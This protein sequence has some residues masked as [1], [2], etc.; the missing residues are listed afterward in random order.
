MNSQHTPPPQI[1]ADATTGV[2]G[3]ILAAA[4]A[5]FSRHGIRAVGVDAI[6]QQ[7]GVAKM[8]L[9]RHFPSKEDLVLAFLN[10]R[11]TLWTTGWLRAEIARRAETPRERLLVLFDVFSEWFRMPGF[12]GCSFI[13]VMLETTDHDSP[14]R[15]ASVECLARVREYLREMSA[16]AGVADPVAF[17]AKWHILMK[18]SIVAAAEGDLRAAARARE[19]GELLLAAEL[20]AELH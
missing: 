20:P 14:V 16:S 6:I 15:K 10:Q 18:G 4:Y 1:S 9:Y 2:R 5:L 7:S 12:E 11:E 19:I 17:A 13:N 3:R 8:T